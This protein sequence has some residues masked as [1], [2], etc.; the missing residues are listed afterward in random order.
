MRNQHLIP[1]GPQLAIRSHGG[2]LGVMPLSP[3]WGAGRFPA[4]CLQSWLWPTRFLGHCSM[5]GAVLPPDPS[6]PWKV[7]SGV[8]LSYTPANKPEQAWA[9]SVSLADRI[10][11]LGK[12]RISCSFLLSRAG[13]TQPQ[14]CSW[15]QQQQYNRLPC[16]WGHQFPG[17]KLYS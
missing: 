6:W 8:W 3:T 11:S 12:M 1:E 5:H 7:S 14:N 17:P 9:G 10:C 13:K 16:P 2:V 15:W 4:G